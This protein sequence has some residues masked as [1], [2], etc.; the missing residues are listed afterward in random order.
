MTQ[1][2][3]RQSFFWFLGV[4][5]LHQQP[6]ATFGFVLPNPTSSSSSSSSVGPSSSRLWAAA[7]NNGKNNSMDQAEIKRQL[8]EYLKTRLEANADEVAKL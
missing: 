1:S 4:L 3:T 6:I 8:K 2:S 7:N 5:V